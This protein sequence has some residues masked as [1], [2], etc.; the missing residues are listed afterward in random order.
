M[1]IK[2]YPHFYQSYPHSYPPFFWSYPHK[3][4]SY[5]H[6]GCY[7]DNSGFYVDNFKVI[8]IAIFSILILSVFEAVD[9][10]DKVIHIYVDNLSILR[11]F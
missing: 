1:L 3:K 2:S 10:V 5:P 9:N 4:L 11:F 7:V 6:S 8:H